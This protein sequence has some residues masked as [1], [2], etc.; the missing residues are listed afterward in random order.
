MAHL[1]RIIIFFLSIPLIIYS[2]W[3]KVNLDTSNELTDIFFIDDSTGYCIG[4]SSMIVITENGGKTWIKKVLDNKRRRLNRIKFYNN[5]GFILG[6]GIVYKTTNLGNNWY[7]VFSDPVLNFADIAFYKTNK[8]WLWAGVGN[9]ENRSALYES[10]DFG[11]TWKYILDTESSSKLKGYRFQS[12]ILT[13]ETSALALCSPFLDPLG[14]TYIYSTTNNGIE[15]DYYSENK[16]YTWGLSS[17]TADTIWAWGAGLELSVDSGKTWSSNV[18]K[19]SREDG[20]LE[21]ITFAVIIDLEISN[22]SKVNFLEANGGQYSILLNKDNSLHW[23]RI[24]VPTTQR[25]ISMLFI[26]KENIWCVG[27]S[28]T[29]IT[30]SDIF[31]SVKDYL[32]FETI[33][34]FEVLGNYPNPFNAITRIK[35]NV[36]IPSNLSLSLYDIEGQEIVLF[37]N[38]FHSRGIYFF[39]ISFQKLNLSSGVYIYSLS[40]SKNT[41][42]NK[43]LLIK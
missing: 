28:G 16:L 30:N 15:W 25:L 13:G 26:D 42:P 40:D 34:S 9:S 18:F 7:P 11:I 29:I 20:S 2:Q 1:I 14:P 6:N 36:N 4:D 8:I 37:S 23:E 39:D 32:N 22:T 3:H 12:I 43:L 5:V 24:G 27:I 41:Y 33:K 21:E 38:I 10:A 17:S 35:Y 19:L 31:S